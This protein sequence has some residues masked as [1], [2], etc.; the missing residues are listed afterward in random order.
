MNQAT[1]DFI[2]TH[3]DDDV[4]QLALRGCKSADI[5]MPFALDQ[6]AGRQTAKCKLPEWY[7]VQGV[8]YPPHISM[9]QCSSECTARYKAQLAVRLG[10]E[11]M[12]DLTGGFGVDFSYMS[13]SFKQ[14]VYVERQDHLCLNAEHNFKLLGMDNASVHH[15]D[16]VEYL[17]DAQHVD[18]LYLDPARRDGNGGKVFGL[19][20]CTPNVVEIEDMLLQKSSYTVLKLSPMLDVH[21]AIQKLGENHVAEVHV[22]SVNNECRELLL[23]L[24]ANQ[25]DSC[26]VYCVNNDEVF[27]YQADSS[28]QLVLPVAG[29]V[30]DMTNSYLYVPNASIMKIGCFKQLAHSFPIRAIDANSHLFLSDGQIDNF[31]GRR[32]RIACISSLN[33]KELR[34]KCGDLVQANVAVRNFPLRAEEL[35]KRLKLR[36]GGDVYLFGTSYSTERGVAHIL[37]RCV[38]C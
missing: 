10:G 30:E 13:R 1:I 11:S 8:I 19:E 22:L 27:S 24:T 2:R 35:K 33:K 7:G 29:N 3:Q 12:A 37:L 4:R 32:F 31:P 20:D 5:D 38:K 15:G 25:V 16:G 28:E 21:A 6:I 18:L 17:H 26:K 36:D 23:V 14:A 34:Q 9:E